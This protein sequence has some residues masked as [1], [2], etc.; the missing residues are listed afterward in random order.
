MLLVEEKGLIVDELQSVHV[1]FEYLLTLLFF[2]YLQAAPLKES[3]YRG[4][5]S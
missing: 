1:H 4:I 2:I 3:L 5:R